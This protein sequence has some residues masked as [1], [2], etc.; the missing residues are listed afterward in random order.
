MV[1]WPVT[2]ERRSLR[3]TAQIVGCRNAV[4]HDEEGGRDGLSELSTRQMD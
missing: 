3:L 2:R 1:R 4:T